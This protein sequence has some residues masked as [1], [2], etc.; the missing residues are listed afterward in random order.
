MWNMKGLALASVLAVSASAS[1]QVTGTFFDASFWGAS[2]AVLGIDSAAAIEGFEDVDLIPGLRVEV[3][4]PNGGYGPTGVLPSTFDPATQDPFGNVF[5]G[6]IWDGTRA[7]IN[8]RTNQPFG[9]FATND[10]GGFIEFSF[11]S[12]ARLFG[13]SVQQANVPFTVKAFDGGGS[14]IFAKTSAGLEA[15]INGGRQ[16]Y[17]RLNAAPGTGIARVRF[18]MGAGDGLIF[19]HLAYDAVPEPSLLAAGALAAAAVMRR[20][21]K[22]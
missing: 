14:E 9:Y 17:L 16:G 4:T 8:T 5:V 6:G 2:D 12:P 13:V 3:Q 22:A 10:W 18:D 19:D 20:R 7:A 1:A 15:P 11:D 21:R